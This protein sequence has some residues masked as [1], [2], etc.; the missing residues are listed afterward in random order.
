VIPALVFTFKGIRRHYDTV[1]AAL[2]VQ[3]GTPLPEIVHTVVVLVGQRV[4]AGVL[5]AIAYAKSLRPHYLHAV[6]VA[7][8]EESAKRVREDWER[9]GLDVPLDIIESPY[10][11]L[12]RPVLEYVDR[13]DERWEHD[14]VT[15]VIPEFVVRHWWEQLLHNQSA[16][17]LKFR[18]LFRKGTVV[19]SIPVVVD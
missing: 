12:T 2:T 16:F 4:H 15:V 7:F 13:L 14:V 8:D 5:Q 18:L 1:T 9:F 6:S 17:W 11:E 19:T 10:R 3:P